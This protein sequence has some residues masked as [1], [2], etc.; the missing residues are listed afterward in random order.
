MERR[1][2]E[3]ALAE[4]RAKARAVLRLNDRGE[5]TTPSRNQYPHQWN[6]D[7]AL[8]ALGLSH[9]DLPRARTEIRSLLRA[10]W[11]EKTNGGVDAY[12]G[13]VDLAFR[14][15]RLSTVLLLVVTGVGGL[16]HLYSVGY[17]KSD[18]GYARYF[19]YLNLFIGSMLIIAAVFHFARNLGG[20]HRPDSAV[21]GGG[22][23]SG[24][25]GG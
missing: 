25:P 17:M 6:W 21:A 7:S 16:I 2:P 12:D 23:S 24:E 11:R 19:S 9:F 20:T 1:D 22:R 4:M 18:A 15:D 3:T 10:Q 14:V 5:F 13:L 8:I